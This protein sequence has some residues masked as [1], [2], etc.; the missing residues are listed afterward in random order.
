MTVETSRIRFTTEDT[1]VTE[2]SKTLIARICNEMTEIINLQIAFALIILSIVFSV[3]SVS[4]VVQF[5]DRS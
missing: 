2:K 5:R 3:P 1:E 4:S